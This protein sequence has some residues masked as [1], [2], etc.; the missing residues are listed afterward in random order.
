[1]Y[2]GNPLSRLR[3]LFR[4]TEYADIFGKLCFVRHYQISGPEPTGML[5][6]SI[7][8]SYSE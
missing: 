3:I 7:K 4:Q 2:K 1:M 5:E 6:I 8:Y